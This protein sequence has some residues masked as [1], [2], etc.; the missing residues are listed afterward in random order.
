[1]NGPPW[2]SPRWAE[3]VAWVATAL[4]GAG[5]FVAH[6]HGA[7]SAV[8]LALATVPAGYLLAWVTDPSRVP[9]TPIGPRSMAFLRG[10][11]TTL[12]ALAAADVIALIAAAIARGIDLAES[13]ATLLIALFAGLV[14][15][16]GGWAVY[17]IT[18]LPVLAVIGAI[19]ARRAGTRVDMKRVALGFLLLSLAVLTSGTGLASRDLDLEGGGKG[20]GLAALV[21]SIVRTD[22]GP[23]VQVWVWVARVGLVAV[24]AC[25]VW[26]HRATQRWR[27]GG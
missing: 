6:A 13:V 19:A 23:E 2:R 21:A 18:T 15:V 22:G 11:G 10:T 1:M 5:L 4:L 20:R 17:A 7:V 25:A 24:V 9:D 14:G 16:F 26:A 27:S 8:A 12:V 3:P